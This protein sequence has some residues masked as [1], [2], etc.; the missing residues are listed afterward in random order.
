MVFGVMGLLAVLSRTDGARAQQ[1]VRAFYAFGQTF[2]VW[3]MK[4]NQ[5]VTYEIYR[6]DTSFTDTSQAVLTGRLFLDEVRGERLNFVAQQYLGRNATWRIPVDNSGATYTLLDSEGLFVFTPHAAADEYFAVV[7]TGET[8]VGADNITA[9]PVQHGYD[10]ID[11]PV[12]CHLQLEGV[13]PQGYPFSVYAMW[14][15]GRDDPNDRRPDVPVTANFAKNGAPHVFCVHT[16]V[17]GP[18]PGPYPAVF[19]MHGSGGRF[20]LFRPGREVNI[21]LEIDRGILV[22]PSE[23]I[24]YQRENQ[25]IGDNTAKWLG[26]VSDFDPFTTAVR[27]DAPADSVV[28]NY[29]MRRVL[30]ILD[31]LLG[32]TSGFEIDPHQVSMLGHSG[33]GL[34]T[35]MITRW[36]PE[37]FASATMFTPGL[38][39]ETSFPDPLQGSPADNLETNIRVGN[40]PLH[41]LDVQ[42]WS[43]RLSNSQRDLCPTRIYL[44]RRDQS[45][46]WTIEKVD[47]YRACDDSALGFFLHWDEREHGV[48]QWSTEDPANPGPDIGQ[49]VSPVRTELGT[50]AYQHRF[51]N[52][53]SF[54][55]FFHDDRE[56]EVVG[57][58]PVI[59]NGD[60]FDGDEWG[61]WSG[62]CDWDPETLVDAPTE[63]SAVIW[64]MGLSGISVDNCPSPQSRISVAP[65]R[66]Q[67]F[68][69]AQGTA[70]YWSTNTLDDVLQDKGIVAVGTE[71]VVRVED[72]LLARDPDRIRLRMTTQA[73]ARAD[74]NWDG[75]IDLGDYQQFASYMRGPNDVPTACPDADLNLDCRVDLADFALFQ[76]AIN[77]PA[78]RLCTTSDTSGC[79]YASRRAYVPRKVGR[80]ELLPAH[81]WGPVPLPDS[82]LS[83]LPVTVWIPEGAPEPLPVVVWSHGGGSRVVPGESAPD[84]ASVLARAGYAVLAMHHMARTQN[85]LEQNVCLPL[86]VP[87]A[88]CD[89]AVYV[90]AYESMDRGLDAIAVLDNLTTIGADWGVT[91]DPDR[92]AIAGHSGGSTAPLFLAGGERNVVFQSP[93][94]EVFFSASDIRPKAFVAMSPP[95]GT[96]AGWIADSLTSINR[97]FL[98]A[99]GIG[100]LT[101]LLRVELHDQLAPGDKFRLFINSPNATH[102]VFNLDTDSTNTV[103]MQRQKTFHRWIASATV[104]FLDA[105][106]RDWVEARS[107]LQSG[108]IATLIDSEVIPS[109]A[110]PSW[111]TR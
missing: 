106:V 27:A 14:S 54:P 105:Y 70:V 103:S 82:E 93:P 92:V 91:F 36:K 40:T 30:W 109:A 42:R 46:P 86:G 31:W 37:R 84:W 56:P 49:W 66:T 20:D 95:G 3:E 26:Y 32:S 107:W 71:D 55:A 35:S 43:V 76:Q 13:T 73:P 81:R 10:P 15:D 5:P 9:A 4:G 33:G 29:S 52:D 97:P 41:V 75:D 78:V 89:P 53:E 60:P 51:R 101:P 8:L 110:I 44:G 72:I 38:H 64:L 16:P 90:N 67:F 63:W 50:A 47:E 21:G 79:L 98:T 94:N 77:G 88:D 96:S 74:L 69:P 59:G 11:D 48:P 65:R 62:Y 87:V 25:V 28:I 22:A 19:A 34:G 17:A 58:Q 104:A 61:T 99:T 45:V 80:S 85:D 83:V 23:H 100:D 57:R 39:R 1:N 2:V 111:D 12:Q 68:Q 102:A 24:V 7:R 18:G 108:N 6:S